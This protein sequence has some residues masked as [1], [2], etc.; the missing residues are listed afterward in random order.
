LKALGVKSSTS[1]IKDIFE[2]SVDKADG[3]SSD[4]NGRSRSSIRGVSV[5]SQFKTSLQNLVRDLE[6]TQPHYIRCLKPNLKKASNDFNAGEALRQLR[7]AG[8]MEAIRIRREGYAHREAHE[9]FYSRFSVLLDSKDLEEGEGI[10]HL[11][12]ILS[13]RLRV[14]DADWQIGHSKI[15]LRQELASKLNKL[16]SLRVHSAAR[17]LGR[18]G[19]IIAQRRASNLLIAWIRL[20]L[21]I[22][23]KKRKMLAASKIQATFR[24]KKQRNTFQSAIFALIKIQSH[25]RRHR[26][27][28]IVAKI[29]DP[30]GDMS[31]KE[32]EK[33][34]TE[35]C[36]RLND[37]VSGKKYDLA[38][39]LEQ[40]L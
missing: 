4:G 18:F 19:R 7:Y 39:E 27:T 10:A 37:A 5:A 32:L 30:Y 14:T 8:M 25:Q 23:K 11:V 36:R 28:K 34:H 6:Q 22:I 1:I 16:V 9:S 3:A 24:M 40:A 21:H 29:R 13:K 31:F 2:H 15:F 33:L 26:A 38:A 35:E 17:I 20:R 12:T